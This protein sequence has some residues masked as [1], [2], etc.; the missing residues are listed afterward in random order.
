MWNCSYDISCVGRN[1]RSDANFQWIFFFGAVTRQR[2]TITPSLNQHFFTPLHCTYFS[3]DMSS[4]SKHPVTFSC[5]A[6]TRLINSVNDHSPQT[7]SCHSLLFF[8]IILLDIDTPS[9]IDLIDYWFEITGPPPSG[10]NC[11]M[12]TK[13]TDLLI[14]VTQICWKCNLY[15]T[16][17]IM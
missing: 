12:M 4:H 10:L 15:V 11:G 6:L 2:L 3:V 7:I 16:Y 14:E 9:I 5:T 1:T 17:F 13:E 8:F